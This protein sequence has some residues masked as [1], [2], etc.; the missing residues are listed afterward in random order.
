MLFRSPEETLGRDSTLTVRLKPAAA[1][2]R[3]GPAEEQEW[4][5]ARHFP[6]HI[7][8]DGR[9][10]ALGVAFEL[11]HP[12]TVWTDGSRQDN[13]TVGAACVWRTQEGWTRLH[14]HLGTNNEV[15]GAE[16]FAIYQA[17]GTLGQ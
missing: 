9:G 11:G 16:T 6:G 1:T 10:T 12:G 5:E 3:D 14:F 15:F 2:G 7:T 8:I 13:G 4:V 17:L